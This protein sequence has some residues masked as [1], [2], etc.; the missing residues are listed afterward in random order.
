MKLSVLV[1]KISWILRNEGV[2]SLWQKAFRRIC[3][4]SL[5]FKKQVA[6]RP[7]HFLPSA[8]DLIRMKEV[9]ARFERMPLISIVL[10]VYN[11]P[12]VF[13]RECL[14]SVLAQIY[15]HWEL[16]VADDASTN[17]EIRNILNEYQAKDERIKIV[18]REKNG[19][20][21]AASNSALEIATGEYVALL[22]HDDTLAP[23]ALFEMAK[24][25]LANP[26]T[27][28]FYSNEDKIDE[29]GRHDSVALKA[30]WSPD[31]F[32]S[33]MYIGHLTMYR[34]S[35]IT[36]V[37][38]FRVGFEG[39][40]DHDLALRVTEKTDKIRH[41]EAVLYHWR[42]HPESVAANLEVKPYAFVSAK[43]AITEALVRRGYQSAFVE[44]TKRPGVFRSRFPF[45]EQS[46]IIVAL[47]AGEKL[48]REDLE[49]WETLFAS[50]SA[51]I[52]VGAFENAE[53]PAG[54]QV[55]Y[56]A[57]TQ[58]AAFLDPAPLALW[59]N[60]LSVY[61]QDY[62]CCFDASTR[63]GKEDALRLLLENISRSDIGVVGAHLKTPARD[64]IH[65]GYL[66]WDG[67]LQ[68]NFFGAH[69]LD[70]GYAAR[71][72]VPTNATAVSSIGWVTRGNDL[73][74]FL[75]VKAQWD[76]RNAFELGF[77]RFLGRQGKRV[78]Y[79]SEGEL[80]VHGEIPAH[81]VDLRRYP[82]DWQFFRE[83]DRLDDYR[84][85]YYPQGLDTTKFNYQLTK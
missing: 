11:P 73:L 65:A 39:S 12:P 66:L 16:C 84:D 13:F 49:Y 19:H 67:K 29:Q 59:R 6:Y 8:E 18:F 58:R 60:A 63:F 2:V 54:A 45:P 44:E 79:H 70:E 42:M 56:V 64:H 85:P 30:C 83:Y 78:L 80:L 15:P 17:P 36:S 61:P 5:F 68:H 9:L 33:F 10:P 50:Y 31:Y 35:L 7:E 72:V 52:I 46:Q 57:R 34:R 41:V 53:V 38:G 82:E 75:A 24:A 81:V 1:A 14:D 76:C 28:I 32:L 69:H 25:L 43:K 51:K 40:Q 47:W 27:D 26:E 23:H 48:S 74:Q 22:D 20:I 4:P 21:S 37:G 55:H 77:C 62:I 3:H 71:L